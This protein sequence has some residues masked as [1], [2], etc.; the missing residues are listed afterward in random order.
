MLGGD[1]V[2]FINGDYTSD[3][4]TK[5]VVQINKKIWVWFGVVVSGIAALTIIGTAIYFAN[6]Q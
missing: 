1:R 3:V 5:F 6:G 2:W 4:T